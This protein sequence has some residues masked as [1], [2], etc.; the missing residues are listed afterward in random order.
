MK[1]ERSGPL[2]ALR[3]AFGW[4]Q[5]DAAERCGVSRTTYNR[6]ETAKRGLSKFR[7]LEAVARGYGISVSDLNDY[8][9]GKKQLAELLQR[10]SAR[11]KEDRPSDAR[12]K[13][14]ETPIPPSA[15]IAR[16]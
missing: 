14:D 4:S 9:A 1:P 10:R 8:I 12:P 16:R 5:D 3:A 6:W 2:T 13:S 11:A 15:M 7:S